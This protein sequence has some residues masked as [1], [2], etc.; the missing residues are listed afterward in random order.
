[1][2]GEDHGSR[3][4]PPGRSGLGNRLGRGREEMSAVLPACRAGSSE[5]QPGLVDEGGGLQGLARG[6]VR[7]LVRRQFA[8]F[9]VNYG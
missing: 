4:S 1:M 8:E 9:L 7:H 3:G 5:P 2:T 6:L